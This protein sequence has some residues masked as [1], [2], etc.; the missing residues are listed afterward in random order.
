[1]TTTSWDAIDVTDAIAPDRRERLFVRLAPLGAGV[2]GLALAAGGRLWAALLVGGGLVGLTQARALSPAF[3]RRFEQVVG[4]AARALAHGVGVALSW[5]LLSVVFVVVILPAALVTLAF[6]QHAFGRP[7]GLPGDGWVPRATLG[8]AGPTERTFG[9]EPRRVPES[10][11]P[12]WLRAVTVVA[13]IVVVDLAAGVALTAFGVPSPDRGDVGRQIRAGVDADM[14]APPIASEPWS[15][16]FGAD[17]TAYELQTPQYVPFLVRG[18]HE[19]HSQYLNTTERERVSYRPTAGS[20]NDPLRVAFFG[21]SAMFDVGQRDDHTIPSA[22]ARMAETH[23]LNLEVHNY[24]VPGWVSWQEFQYLER[25]L[26]EGQDY[27]LIVFY[28]G[29]NEFLVQ[30]AGLSSDPTHVGAAEFQG[31]ATRYYQEHETGPGALD[32]LRELASA[33]GRSSAIV[34]ILG[35]LRGD[36][37]ATPPQAGRATSEQVDTTLG[38]YDRSTRMVSDLARDHQTPVRYFWQPRRQGWANQVTDRL[39]PGV[40]DLSEVFRGHENDVYIDEVHTNE[41]GAATVAAAMW[42]ELGPEL[43]R[44]A[45]ARG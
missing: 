28:D 38:V 34:R 43:E 33:Y 4:R 32:G 25:L 29:F 42:A 27:D 36:V 37:A 18:V 40:T 7:R 45:S 16:D 2:V 13:V 44:Q 31:L 6:R 35:E 9:A 1:M 30:Q 41:D 5:A 26:A 11:R 23:G 21:G 3:A 19:F 39:P 24:G 12:R 15:D 22:F 17:L 14:N 20:A 10:R 8:P